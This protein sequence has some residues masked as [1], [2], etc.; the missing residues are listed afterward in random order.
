M[1]F[2]KKEIKRQETKDIKCQLIKFEHDEIILYI[3]K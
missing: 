3:Q 2:S 1:V